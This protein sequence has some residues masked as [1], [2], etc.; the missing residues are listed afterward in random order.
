M[1]EDTINKVIEQALSW[2]GTPYHPCARV[3]GAGVDCG[4]LLIEVYAD[5]GACSRFDPGSYR[6]DWHLH[7]TEELYLGHV[8]NY[9]DEV[10]LDQAKPGDALVYKYGRTWSHGAILVAPGRV[11]HAY[12]KLGVII[13]NL[14]EHP[15]A[16]RTPRAF[17]LKE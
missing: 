6:P 5:A 11:V 9:F 14:D 4:M 3:K 7:R 10:P 16:G 13:S 1:K 12:I 15:L 2:V 17:T 8:L